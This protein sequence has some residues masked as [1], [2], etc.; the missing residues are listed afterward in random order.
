MQS[1]VEV[2]VQ[3]V[4]TNNLEAQAYHIERKKKGIKDKK[5]IN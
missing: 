3:M 5:G 2:P 4:S 1:P